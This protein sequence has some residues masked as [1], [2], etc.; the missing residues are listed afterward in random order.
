MTINENNF[1]A[2]MLDYLNGNLDPLTSAELMAFLAENPGYEKLLPTYDCNVMS[3]CKEHLPDKELLKKD[4]SDIPAINVS[5]FD[6]FCIAFSE[7][8]LKETDR[9]RLAYYLKQNPERQQDFNLYQ[10]LQLRIDKNIRYAG[11]LRLKR[12]VARVRVLRYALYTIGIAASLVL[13]FIQINRNQPEE[14]PEITSINNRSDTPTISSPAR[15]ITSN[16][17]KTISEVKRTIIPGEN[18]IHEV[19]I[20]SQNQII[21]HDT[22]K[23]QPLIPITIAG[24]NS[25]II[26]PPLLAHQQPIRNHEKNEDIFL[27]DN[28]PIQSE[29]FLDSNL[30]KFIKKLNY[31]KAAE[32]VVLGFNYLTESQLSLEK[33]TDENG[34]LTGF[35]LNTESYSISGNKMK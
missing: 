7:N 22:F 12:Q 16:T 31:W 14:N 18:Y 24:I 15:V 23:L 33:Q 20:V 27:A 30:G 2:Y 34:K 19:R 8:L 9:L 25:R 32:T 10:I 29:S 11:K 4:F 3:S 17:E 35:S 28:G 5:N 13:L 26:H 6:E 21:K 1:E